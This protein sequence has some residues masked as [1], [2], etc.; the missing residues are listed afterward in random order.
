M[1]AREFRLNPWNGYSK[2]FIASTRRALGNREA[3]ASD[4]PSLNTLCKTMAAAPGRRASWATEQ[5]LISRCHRIRAHY[6]SDCCKRA[7][8]CVGYVDQSL[9]TSTST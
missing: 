8:G 2:D 6:S 4:F 7:E 3:R 9:V 1:T 5:S